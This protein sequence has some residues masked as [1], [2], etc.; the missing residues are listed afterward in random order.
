MKLHLTATPILWAALMSPVSHAQSFTEMWKNARA[1]EPTLQASHASHT[2][3]VERTNQAIAALRPQLS[4]SYSHNQNVRDYQQT[5][6]S[7]DTQQQFDSA[8]STV[9]LT[10]PIWRS[11]SWHSWNQA[12]ESQSQALHQLGSTEQELAARF[13]S[14]WFDVMSTRDTLR[15][16]S[17]QANAAEHQLAVYQ[18]GLTIGSTTI[19]QRDESAGKYQQALAEQMVAQTDYESKLAA[20]EQ[21]TG[22]LSS[23][24][25]PILQISDN[26]PLLFHLEP[27]E[28]WLAKA[29][30]QNFGILAS[31]AAKGA[32]QHEVQKQQAQHEPTLDFVASLTNTDQADAGNTP[33]QSGFRSKQ[34]SFGVQLSI[35]LYAGGGHSAKVREAN[36]LFMRAEFELDAVRRATALQVKQSWWAAKA[37]LSKLGSTKQAVTAAQTALR[38]AITGKASGLKTALDELQAKQQ[39]AA[40]QRDQFQVFYDNIVAHAKLRA[41]AGELDENFL[42]AIQ[43]VLSDEIS[44]QSTPASA[45]ITK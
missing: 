19:V 24:V 4:A 22:S 31:M 34:S 15:F 7:S 2:A 28:L 29:D 13:L 41:A 38:A 14:S 26:H 25:F 45:K 20:V 12:K 30:S 9:S 27:L 21:L 40:A 18:R 35:P 43:L 36:A 44:A 11:A 1:Y 23:M 10:Q 5:Q 32:A 6:P 8:T 3:A 37:S 39:L 16:T 33:I 17:A 42:Q